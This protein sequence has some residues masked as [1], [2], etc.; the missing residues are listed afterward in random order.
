MEWVVFLWLWGAVRDFVGLFALSCLIVGD[1][2]E[3]VCGLCGVC[4]LWLIEAGCS[5]MGGSEMGN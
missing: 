4:L 1:C 3:L 2:K 5:I